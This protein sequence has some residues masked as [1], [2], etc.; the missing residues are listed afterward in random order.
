MKTSELLSYLQ[1]LEKEELN[2]DLADAI[3]VLNGIEN[4]VANHRTQIDGYTQAVANDIRNL[5]SAFNQFRSTINGLKDNLKTR[6]I[7][8]YPE[9]YQKS[10]QLYENE[11][12]YDSNDYILNRKLKASEEGIEAITANL[13]KYTDWRLPGLCIRPGQERF[14]E[15][16]VPLYPLYVADANAELLAPCISKFTPEFQRRLC[17]YNVDDY[18]DKDPLHELP[19]NQFGLIFAYNF[20][21]YKPLN[22]IERYLN[23]FAQKLRPGGHAI[24]TYNDCDIAQGMGLAEKSF[25]C[26]TPGS[27]VEQLILSAGLDIVN[28]ERA[29]LDLTWVDVRKPGEIT[30]IKGGQSLAKII[31]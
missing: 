11:M 29:Y 5:E 26:F 7:D 15:D 24:F 20:L 19:N 6:I 25:M 4:T 14:V 27:K 1:V 12:I 30:S 2:P 16:M 18:K 31:S 17:I 8:C 9:L 13:K 3:A 22:I 28:R 21:N 10:Q 23:G